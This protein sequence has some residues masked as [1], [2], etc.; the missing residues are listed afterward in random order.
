MLSLINNLIA[1]SFG[2]FYVFLYTISSSVFNLESCMPLYLCLL[3]FLL[4]FV[5]ICSYE[6]ID[7]IITIIAAFLGVSCD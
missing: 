1:C 2:S 3:L 7:Y 6:I 4:L 5:A